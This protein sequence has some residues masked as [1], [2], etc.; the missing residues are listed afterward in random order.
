MILKRQAEYT[1]Y[2]LADFIITNLI[3]YLVLKTQS[4]IEKISYNVTRTLGKF[5]SKLF[6]KFNA[7]L[8]YI[9]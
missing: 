3:N 6:T 4:I 5:S 9:L 2:I 7:L 1:L 8:T